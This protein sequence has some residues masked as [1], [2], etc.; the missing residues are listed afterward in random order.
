MDESSL[1]PNDLEGM[2]CI[3]AQFHLA[4]FRIYIFHVRSL[5]PISTDKC[6]FVYCSLLLNISLK[7][8]IMS[9]GSRRI[10]HYFIMRQARHLTPAGKP[11]YGC[12][13]ISS[14]ILNG[15]FDLRARHTEIA[16]TSLCGA[17]ERET[18]KTSWNTKGRLKTEITSLQGLSQRPGRRPATGSEVVR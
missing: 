8:C 1:S 5:L 12:R 7:L 15:T 14:S 9:R 3:H 6:A 4:I 11:R 16:W 10:I 17:V 13:R 18:Y 2:D